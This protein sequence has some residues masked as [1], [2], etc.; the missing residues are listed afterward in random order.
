MHRLAPLVFAIALAACGTETIIMPG[1]SASD[2][3]PLSDAG[4]IADGAADGGADAGMDA[5]A[6]ARTDGGE[7]AAERESSATGC[8][9]ST[10]AVY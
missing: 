6:D 7:P 2:A 10:V 4:Q 1:G 5:G 3:A 9:C 8:S